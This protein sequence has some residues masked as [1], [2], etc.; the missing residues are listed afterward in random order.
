MGGTDNCNH[1]TDPL[2]L[3][4][5]GTSRD[6]R[7]LVALDAAKVPLDER[8]PAYQMVFAQALSQFLIY[9]DSGN[10][11]VDDWQSF[12]SRDVS[13]Q[14]AMASIQ[15]VDEYRQQIKEGFDFLNNLDNAANSPGLADVLGQ[16]FSALGTLALRLDNIKEELPP[17]FALKHS[18]QNL[19]R[20]QL[21]PAFKKLL[22]YYRDGLNP[23]PPPP[24]PFLHDVPPPMLVLG[25]SKTFAAVRENGLSKDWIYEDSATDWASYRSNLDDTVLYPDTQIYGT[26]TTLF[27]RTNFISGHN[28]FK[29]IFDQFLKAYARVVSDARAAL[30]MSFTQWDSHGPHYALFLAFVRL[31]EYARKEMN[32]LTGRHLDYYFREILRLKERPAQAS[33]A[34]LLAELAKHAGSYEFK[35]NVLLKA[36]KDDSGKEAFYANDRDFIANQAVVSSVKTLYQHGAEPVGTGASANKQNG[37]LYASPVAN[38]DDGIGEPLTSDDLSWHP[39]HHKQYEDGALQAILMP[40]AELGFAVASHYLYL[41]EGERAILLLLEVENG[42]GASVPNLAGQITCR[43]TTEKGWLE[44]APAYFGEYA[45]NRLMLYLIIDGDA[46]PISG[47]NP[48]VHNYELETDL[49]VLF[50]GLTHDPMTPYAYDALRDIHVSA[51][52]LWVGV[53]GL[54]RLAVSNDFGP[55]DTSKPFQ[56]FGAQPQ[57]NSALI[58]GSKEVFQKKLVFAEINM[59]WQNPPQ[60]FETTVVVNADYLHK[61]EWTPS[62]N[63]AVDISNSQFPL[64]NNTDKPVLDSPDSSSNEF[65]STQSKHGFIR[66]KLNNHFGQTNFENAL[67]DYIKRVT[68]NDP[69]NDGVKPTPPS[70]PFAASLSMD[71][72]ARQSIVLNSSTNLGQRAARYYHILPFGHAERHPALVSGAKVHLL[73]QF[74][75]QRASSMLRSEAEFYIGISGLEPPQSLALLFQVADGTADPLAQK[76]APHIHWSYLT[77]NE[78]IPFASNEVDDATAGLLKSGIITFAFPRHAS[79]ANTLLPAGQHWIRA[80]VNSS[81][82]AVCRLISVAAQAFGATFT[83]RDNDPEFAAKILE[84]GVI[85]KLDRPD[86]AVKKIHQPFATF[87]G[88]SAEAPNDFYTRVSER[89]RHKD[90]AIALWDYERLVLEAFPQVFRVKCLNHTQYEPT[91]SG[92]GIYRELAPGHVTLVCIPRAQSQNLRNPLRPYTSLGMLEDIHHY[93]SKRIPCFVKLHVRN[94]QFEEVRVKFKLRLFAGFDETYYTLQ[95]RESIM[96]FLSPWAFAGGGSPSF[97]GKV[98]KATLINFVEEQPYVDYVTDFQMFHDVNG[99]QGTTDLPVAVGALAIS[100]LVSVPA[101][102]HDIHIIHPAE[103]ETPREKCI[104]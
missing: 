59:P 13:V 38:S 52:D 41:A 86:A 12:F 30:E 60:P 64:T 56:P 35:A 76:P 25:A 19:I 70:G 81:S 40:H 43:L 98:Y 3:E 71:Y 46:P 44:K 4:R 23:V 74:S 47:L 50:V 24:G 36:G 94:P 68:D 100:I 15:N 27:E 77:G 8:D 82:D 73:P 53:A 48:K 32:T 90:R 2:K 33:K 45:A 69:S 83:D 58:I 63:T 54:K 95:L 78:W 99:I 93:L 55:V 1:N 51:I 16:L 7:L 65:Y 18:L 29:S 72:V 104:C 31:L 102:K 11:P 10:I 85:S 97:G 66:L 39:L 79:T 5:E 101:K 62:E 14:L 89:L 20:T 61:G 87:G 96:R 92:T 49:P 9:F 6:Q 26:G 22:L 37:R 75:F 103:E 67:I 21:A 57:N 88:R 80:A 42:S 34:H 91:E 28:L 84:A 17:E